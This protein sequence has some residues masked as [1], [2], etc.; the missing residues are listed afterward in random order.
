MNAVIPLNYENSQVTVSARDL[1][2]F[3]EIKTNF[4]DWFPRMIEYGLEEGEDFNPLKNERVR[5]EGNRE[6]LREI[7]DY[8]LTIDAAK[9][10]AMIQR[11]DKG[12]QARKYFIQI[13]KAWNDPEL[14]F[15]RAL[16][17]ANHH[18]QKKSHELMQLREEL[19]DAEP[20]VEA[21]DQFM[22][23]KGGIEMGDAAKE[24]NIP[25]IGRNKLFRILRDIKILMKDNM[26]YQRYIDRGYFRIKSESYTHPVTGERVSYTQT[27]VLPKGLNYIYNVLKNS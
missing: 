23:A 24:L 14:V 27:L 5:F 8:L 16:N 13:E 26:P 19:S 1:H 4:R 22:C 9:Q 6:V 25:G 12:R 21:F 10:I 11:N 17:L 15:A 7:T 18:L 3:L 20:K 2:E